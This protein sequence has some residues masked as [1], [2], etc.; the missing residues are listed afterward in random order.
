MAYLQLQAGSRVVGSELIVQAPA[1]EN[2]DLYRAYPLSP[3][4][5][6]SQFVQDLMV[7]CLSIEDRKSL[8]ADITAEELRK[9]L[10]HLQPDKVP[11][12]SRFPPKYWRLVWPQAGQPM[13]EM[14]QEALKRDRAPDL[15]LGIVV[16]FST[17]CILEDN[18]LVF[19][20]EEQNDD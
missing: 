14:F 8:E 6:L 12:P 10:A 1:A 13:L 5:D 20:I 15:F 7:P 4:E 19:E 2:Q 17:L 18:I 11:G 16:D 9:A 3:C